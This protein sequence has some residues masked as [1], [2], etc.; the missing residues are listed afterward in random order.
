[1]SRPLNVVV[2]PV[3]FAGKV[4]LIKRGKEPYTGF[5]ALIG[6]KV[7]VG[8]GIP[9][10]IV[11]E[12]AEET[13]LKVKFVGIRGVVYETLYNSKS[14]VDH[15][16]I[17]VCETKAQTNN[18]A[19]SEEGEIKWFSKADLAK[20]KDQIVP[21]DFAIIKAFPQGGR[22]K[23]KLHTSKMRARGKKYLLEFFG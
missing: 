8:E 1:M 16:V 9:K 6:G 15:F 23:I 12:V 3:R 18:S 21:S 10:A 17:W 4:L 2:S 20:F 22:E 14:P 13:G 11:R 7:E 19:R 5:W